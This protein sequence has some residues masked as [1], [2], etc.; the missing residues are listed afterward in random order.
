M[1]DLDTL[2]AALL[3]FRDRRA[4]RRFHTPRHLA[5]SVAIEAAELL[6]LTQWLRDEEFADWAASHRDEVAGECADILSYLI[7]FADSLG[8]DLAEAVRTK[9]RA[10]E[11][12]F[13]PLD[14]SHADEGRLD[15]EG[16]TPP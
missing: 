13:P 14:D 8:I 5:T 2:R 10:N 7:L 6:E 15:G 3:A 11:T 4:W 9:M 12:R 16:A 1:T